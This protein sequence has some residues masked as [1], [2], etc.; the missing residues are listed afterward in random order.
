[1]ARLTKLLLVLAFGGIAFGTSGCVLVGPGNSTIYV[2]KLN[3]YV[4]E[5]HAQSGGVNGELVTFYR[6]DW[7]P[8]VRDQLLILPLSD[9][10]LADYRAKRQSHD[11]QDSS[12]LTLRDLKA[13]SAGTGGISDSHW[14]NAL[15]DSK[16][17]DFHD[18]LSQMAQAS[19]TCIAVQLY[20]SSSNWT[21]RSG[22]DASCNPNQPD[23]FP[24]EKVDDEGTAQM[25]VG[26]CSKYDSS[27][28]R[29]AY[30]GTAI[31]TLRRS[32]TSSPW[33]VA[34]VDTAAS[35]WVR[36]QPVANTVNTSIWR[37][38][39]SDGYDE[40]TI[41][42]SRYNRDGY[43]DYTPADVYPWNTLAGGMRAG[44]WQNS[45]GWY[46]YSHLVGFDFNNDGSNDCTVVMPYGY[47]WYKSPANRPRR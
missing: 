33:Y 18:A 43:D 37:F 38:R 15:A 27:H 47:P 32:S 21:T 23:V 12:I 17:S 31:H 34:V 29:I 6:E 41:T 45:D 10:L 25:W 5:M 19:D 13:W 9:T 1:M 24:A 26:S 36:G 11:I 44:W 2:E 30:K 4:G 3:R 8:D 46:F 20:S 40:V 39:G 7:N 42:G 14:L 35:D 16:W 28:R 22:T